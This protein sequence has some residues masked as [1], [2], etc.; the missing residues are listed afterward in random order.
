MGVKKPQF[1]IDRLAEIL[2][3]AWK[4]YP[5]LEEI[6]NSQAI[7]KLTY[8]EKKRE[9][10]RPK[11]LRKYEYVTDQGSISPLLAGFMAGLRS[12]DRN[13]CY[14]DTSKEQEIKE[15]DF[16]IKIQSFLKH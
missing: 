12:V 15:G 1:K 9:K 11:H 6:Q 3:K 2:G 4:K 8:A 13:P 14:L 16:T 10:E 7:K 5:G